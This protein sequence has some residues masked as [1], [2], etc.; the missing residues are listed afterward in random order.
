MAEPLRVRLLL[1]LRKSTFTV[2]ELTEILQISQ[3]NASHHLKALRENGLIEALKSGQHSYYAIVAGEHLHAKLL[4][5]LETL[6]ELASEISDVAGDQIRL[7]DVLSR[8]AKTN[9]FKDWRL[10][11]PDLPYSDLFARLSV[12]YKDRV[13]DIG[14]G[15]GDFFQYL[16][17]NFR[18]VSAIDVDIHRLQK[19]RATAK[20]LQA[21]SAGLYC[22]DAANL[23]FADGV[24]DSVIF[25]MTFSHLSDKMQCLSEASRV[26]KEG[27]VISIIDSAL[28]DET[29]LDLIR[30][31][32]RTRSGVLKV[33]SLSI[34]K[35]VYLARLIRVW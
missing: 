25:R 30:D 2:S 13:C 7:R 21:S 22:A 12:G 28:E 24:F 18:W 23:P 11:Q 4:Q 9:A 3:S 31:I 16:T 26:L 27:G 5:W 19:A 6:D 35:P 34:Y 10:S 8:R 14:C 1:L 15:E 29:A 32:D 17:Q 20:G 33:E